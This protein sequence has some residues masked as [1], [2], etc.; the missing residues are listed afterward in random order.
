MTAVAGSVARAERLRVEERDVHSGSHARFFAPRRNGQFSRRGRRRRLGG[1]GSRR[2]AADRPR[3]GTPQLNRRRRSA[4]A[5]RGAP[6][7]A[8]R[9]LVP[10]TRR[11]CLC[12]IAQGDDAAEARTRRSGHANGA[13]S[14]ATARSSGPASP[15]SCCWPATAFAPRACSRAGYWQPGWS[16]RRSHL[17]PRKARR[18][19]SARACSGRAAPSVG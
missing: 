11:M 16:R 10:G 18:G 5:D 8:H 14:S 19:S 6:R 1:P 13:A 12:R 7:A 17:P 4:A 15:A 9:R 3:Q 2:A